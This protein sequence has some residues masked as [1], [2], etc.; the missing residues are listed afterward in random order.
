VAAINTVISLGYYARVLGPAFFE[1]GKGAQPVLAPAA[2][3]IAVSCGAGVVLAGLGSGAV[4]GWMR[5][6]WLLPW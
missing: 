6:A 1:D 2:T 3:I 5:G 4:L